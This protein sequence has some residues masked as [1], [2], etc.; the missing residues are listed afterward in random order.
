MQSDQT[1]IKEARLLSQLTKH[2]MK[3]VNV[4]RYEE[5]AVCCSYSVHQTPLTHCTHGPCCTAAEVC[6]LKV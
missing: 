6:E 2:D 4:I 5:C 1:A 3:N